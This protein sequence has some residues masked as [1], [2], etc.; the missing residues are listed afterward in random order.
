MNKV[1]NIQ[2][3]NDINS[4][5][6]KVDCG[7]DAVDDGVGV[8]SDV[9]AYPVDDWGGRMESQSTIEASVLC[10]VGDEV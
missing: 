10:L 7:L 1:F 4:G 3:L 9:D 6:G 5:A 2:P 8:L